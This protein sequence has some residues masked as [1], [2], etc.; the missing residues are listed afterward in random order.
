MIQKSLE[1]RDN[2]I[3]VGCWEKIIYMKH[4]NITFT[5]LTVNFSKFK[6]FPIAGTRSGFSKATKICPVEL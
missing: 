4:S 2:M 5:S 1:N 3:N 6:N